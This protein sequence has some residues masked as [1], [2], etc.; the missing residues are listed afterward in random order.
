[1]RL[2]LKL[3]ELWAKAVR[4]NRRR[5]CRRDF[6]R[7]PLEVKASIRYMGEDPDSLIKR[8]KL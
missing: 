3:I 4:W 6:A 7:L 5:R 8:G 1:M 2:L